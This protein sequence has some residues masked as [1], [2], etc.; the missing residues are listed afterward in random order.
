ADRR[1]SEALLNRLT[2]ARSTGFL[3]LEDAEKWAQQEPIGSITLRD[4]PGHE[5]QLEIYWADENHAVGKML[6]RNAFVAFEPDLISVLSLSSREF[7]ERSILRL[8]IDSVDRIRIRKNG[9]TFQLR[10]DGDR[11]RFDGSPV[12]A[13][14]A[15]IDHLLK[16]LS[17]PGLAEFEADTLASVAN[18][19]MEN[20]TASIA[21]LAY[22]SE[23]TVHTKAGEH[24]LAEVRF[25]A[26]VENQRVYA[27]SD[28]E[29]YLFS[30]P[31]ET[32][33]ALPN[34]PTDWRDPL[35]LR[36]EPEDL[37]WVEESQQGSRVE[38]DDKDRWRI[39][40]G[41]GVLRDSVLESRARTLASLKA[42]RWIQE[43]PP[44]HPPEISFRFGWHPASANS[45]TP[46]T[47]QLWKHDQ[48]WLG[49]LEGLA[50]SENLFLLS[51]PQVELLTEPF[52]QR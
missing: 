45:E 10:R 5:S 26:E 13:D 38:R 35:V 49:R 42:V 25:G 29:P 37:R 50:E 21:F 39:R 20:P 4:E 46:L 8:H 30:V 33:E 31:R 24:L 36:G 7:R 34:S 3:A 40:R 27:A 32:L 12:Y 52:L 16:L 14:P 41:R 17:T 22:S 1:A 15:R 11:W 47:L 19:G 43:S 9:S 48:G 44:N 28:T 6:D 51:Q 2:S 23:N 18:T